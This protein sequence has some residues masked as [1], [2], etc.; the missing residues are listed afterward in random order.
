MK[1]RKAIAFVLSLFTVIQTAAFSVSALNV[2]D[3]DKDGSVNSS[4]ALIVLQ[5][6]VGQSEEIDLKRADID[7]DGKVNSSDAL[8]ILQMSVGILPLKAE[9]TAEQLYV[10]SFTSLVNNTVISKNMSAISDSYGSRWYTGGGISKAYNYIVS[11]LKA[12][13]YADADIVSDSFTAKNDVKLKNIYCTIPSSKKDADILVFCAHYDSATDGKGSVDNASGVCTVLELARVMKS[14]K[15]DF[16]KE[17]RFCFFA[18]EEIGYYGAYRYCTYIK[19][20][21]PSVSRH[22]LILNIDMAAHPTAK[23]NWYLCVSTEPLTS[24][25]SY[26]KAAKNYTSNS[27]DA[28]KKIVGSCGEYKYV[29]PVT[30]GMHDLL[31]FRKNSIP[32][33]TLSWREVDKSRSG[34]CD[35][36]LASPSIIHTGSDLVKN[37]DMN[38]LYST[39]RLVAAT[40][41]EA[42]FVK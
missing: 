41:A 32:G 11:T 28:A 4:D 21:K 24:T 8:A 30:A 2:G 1:S 5:Y 23:K 9:K 3:L 14:M 36:D 42:T 31:P 17:I 12:C 40:A 37:T 10:E 38:S 13:G 19:N 16:G 6:A 33:A 22:K 27:I 39:V 18:G 25:Y 29:S 35:M 26:R 20:V 15:K 34:G 7:G